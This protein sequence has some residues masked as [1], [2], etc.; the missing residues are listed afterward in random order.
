MRPHDRS[1]HRKTDTHAGRIGSLGLVGPVKEMLEDIGSVFRG[2][3]CAG[4]LHDHLKSI[5]AGVRPYIDGPARNVIFDGV[6]YHD[7]QSFA[8]LAS[9]K[10]KV[11]PAG[12][13]FRITD[14]KAGVFNVEMQF[15]EHILQKRQ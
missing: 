7:E 10:V 12:R 6:I 4:V 1:G 5:F 13:I 3:A 11:R 8:D 2:D 14:R 9:V 15:L